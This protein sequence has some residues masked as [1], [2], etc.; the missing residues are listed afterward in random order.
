M[1]NKT[2]YKIRRAILSLDLTTTE[3]LVLLTLLIRVD[4]TTFAGEVSAIEVSSILN[5]NIR[6]IQR[7]MSKLKKKKFISRYSE[8]T[9]TRNK[10]ALT[11]INTN[12]ILK[13]D[14]IV[15]DKN[16]AKI[17]SDNIVSDN[18]DALS[19]NNDALSDN[20]DALSDNNDTL[21]NSFDSFNLLNK[22][23]DPVVNNESDTH[24]VLKSEINKI[25]QTEF[26]LNDW[27]IR[28]IERQVKLT[29]DDSFANRKR[30]AK[31][32]FKIQLTKGGYYEK[33]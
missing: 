11:Q 32:L 30:I 1:N 8:K 33:I 26:K 25:E 13:S 19:D 27:Q 29:R 10:I 3:R 18:N 9:G 6:T 4:W 5:L 12:R 7:A 23:P 17:T 2:E 22:E 31:R 21:F 28:A 16:D 14:N 24:V 15:S 20:N